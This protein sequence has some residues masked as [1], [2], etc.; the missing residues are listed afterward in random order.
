[1]CKY[2]VLT[3]LYYL[4]QQKDKTKQKHGD[5]STSN[6][7][8]F[9]YFFLGGGV[10]FPLQIPTYCKDPETSAI[11]SNTVH[12]GQMSQDPPMEAHALIVVDRIDGA[13]ALCPRQ[14]SPS[15]DL[16]C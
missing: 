13:E 10:F 1:M 9:F 8:Q 7:R 14:L 6:Q 5:D 16:H 15:K 11:K 12:C 3:I 4:E 2:S